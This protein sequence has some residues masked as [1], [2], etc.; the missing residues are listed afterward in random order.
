MTH[1]RE[2]SLALF[3][4]GDLGL[5]AG[6]R[7]WLHLAR[8]EHCRRTVRQF[9]AVRDSL[10]RSQPEMPEG[11][12]WD[13][14]AAEMTANIHVGL[15]AG[16]CVG[17]V[18][19]RRAR[20]RWHRA[21]ILAPAAVPVIVLLAVGI[22]RQWPRTQ[23]DRSAWVDGTLVEAT[24]EGIQWKQGD[25]MLSLQHPAAAEV[26]YAVNAEGTLRAGYVDAETG[27]VTIHS[28]YAQ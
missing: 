17:P 16:E 8:C 13:R 2:S 19:V 12:S 6:W 26:T 3:A 22:W 25:R 28:V 1:P 14:L 15:A 24:S 7:V 27:Q 11:V 20:P 21:V 9:Q 10:R 4:G 5:L 18:A 23:P